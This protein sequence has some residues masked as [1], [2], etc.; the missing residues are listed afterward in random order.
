MKNVVFYQHTSSYSF[1]VLL[2][3]LNSL[4][5]RSFEIKLSNNS[6]LSRDR[7]LFLISHIKRKIFHGEDMPGAFDFAEKELEKTVQ[8]SRFRVVM[9]C[10]HNTIR[11]KMLYSAYVTHRT[12]MS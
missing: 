7:K 2:N 1:L 11:L 5:R 10:V 9:V 6:K 12:L 3:F 4:I 8:E